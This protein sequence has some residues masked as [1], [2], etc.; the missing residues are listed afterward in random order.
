MR[1]AGIAHDLNNVLTVVSGYAEIMKEDLAGNQPMRENA[2][3][4]LAA[5]ER[6]K[7][8]TGKLF[9]HGTIQADNKTLVNLNDVVAETLDFFR[10]SLPRG[11][12]VKTEFCTSEIPVY[13]DP[14]ELVRVF[15]NITANAVQAM[16]EHG[17]ILSVKT[18][19]LEGETDETRADAQAVVRGI[20]TISDTGCGMDSLKLQRVFDLWFTSR[21]KGSGKGLGLYV[22]R[23]II[24]GLG[25]SICVSSSEGTGSV[26]TVS[27]PLFNRG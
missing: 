10:P 24:T 16:E 3:K 1:A 2:E 4:I 18:S 11:I 15:M 7:S 23:E 20:V 17:G 22:S 27:L 14:S 25:G 13:A 9:D 12:E 19:V 8:L 26:F 21:P 5:V 6:A